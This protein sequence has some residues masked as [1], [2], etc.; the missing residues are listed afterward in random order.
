M[1]MSMK[2]QGEVIKVE[3]KQGYVNDYLEVTVKG[4]KMV[5]TFEVPVHR[6]KSYP[7]GR[8]VSVGVNAKD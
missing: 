5:L 2:I 7:M 4:S 8:F 6:A 3:K 1:A